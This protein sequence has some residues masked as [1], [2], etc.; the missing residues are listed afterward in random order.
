MEERDMDSKLRIK[1]RLIKAF[2]RVM[3]IASIAAIAGAIALMVVNSKYSS[4]LVNYGFSQGDIG[5]AMTAFTGTR[6]YMLAA[7]GYED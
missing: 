6:A 1:E 5:K 2:R 3:M 7:I 4:A